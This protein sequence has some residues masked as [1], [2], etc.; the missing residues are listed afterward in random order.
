M[1]YHP[2]NGELRDTPRAVSKQL[3]MGLK[4]GAPDLIVFSP[5]G[6]AFFIEFKSASGSLDEAQRDFRQ[7]ATR[8]GFPYYVVRSVAQAIEIFEFWDALRIPRA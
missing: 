5:Q 2:P 7:W 8:A 1:A 6:K 4:P 3:A